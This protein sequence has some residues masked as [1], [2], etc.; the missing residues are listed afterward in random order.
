MVIRNYC[1]TAKDPKVQQEHIDA[2]VQSGQM[3]LSLVNNVLD[4]S[5]LESNKL[6]LN[7]TYFYVNEIFNQVESVFISVARKKNIQFNFQ[8]DKSVPASL[9]GD[10]SQ[11]K[12][13][14]VN[15]SR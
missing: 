10:A 14:L 9:I 8:I 13:I 11:L 5:K 12:Q 7:P 4:L 15:L 6:E 2:I 3:L 1:S